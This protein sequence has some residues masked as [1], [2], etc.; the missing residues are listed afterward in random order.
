MKNLSV[1]DMKEQYIFKLILIRGITLF[2]TG[3]SSQ[4]PCFIDGL[5]LYVAYLSSGF[6]NSKMVTKCEPKPISMNFGFPRRGEGG[7]MCGRHG[8]GLDWPE[9]KDNFSNN[10]LLIF[11]AIRFQRS[12]VANLLWNIFPNFLPNFNLERGI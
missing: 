5:L 11:A 9:E 10:I 3:I 8:A 7:F 12:Y 2:R 6:G 4:I 1:L